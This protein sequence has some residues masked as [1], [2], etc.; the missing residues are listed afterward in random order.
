MSAASCRMIYAAKPS[1]AKDKKAFSAPAT[2]GLYVMFLD[3]VLRMS[4]HDD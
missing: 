1:G 3:G 2:L 4:A